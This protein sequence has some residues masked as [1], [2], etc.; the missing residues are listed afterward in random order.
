MS[1]KSKNRGSTVPG[2]KSNVATE[3]M[4]DRKKLALAGKGVKKRGKWQASCRPLSIDQI[5]L[6]EAARIRLTM[7]LPALA[8]AAVASAVPPAPSIAAA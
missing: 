5:W 2:S 8:A 7:K 1:G 6:S 4:N 3:M